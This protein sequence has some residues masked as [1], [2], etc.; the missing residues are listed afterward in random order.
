VRLFEATDGRIVREWAAGP[1]PSGSIAVTPQAIAVGTA[2]RRIRLLDPTRG[3]AEDRWIHFGA[4]VSGLTYRQ[5]ALF[6]AGDDGRLASFD[7]ATATRLFELPGGRIAWPRP[8]ALGDKVLV[9][10]EG[11]LVAIEPRTGRVLA[12]C[13]ITTE[14]AGGPVVAGN[15]VVLP[16]R[17]GTISCLR[18]EDLTV[19]WTWSGVGVVPSV[20]AAKS[21]IAG[22]AGSSL[23]RFETGQ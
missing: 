5:D 22:V 1:R 21:L 14:P 11:R 8:V 10:L 12:K 13:P 9:D 18:A 17:D 6:A 3:D 2:D 16:L 23:V 15:F 4:P 19:E 7:V 20:G